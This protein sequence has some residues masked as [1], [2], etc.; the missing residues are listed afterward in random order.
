MFSLK[1][2]GSDYSFV[3]TFRSAFF[4]T[5]VLHIYFEEVDA[6]FLPE[7]KHRQL[8]EKKLI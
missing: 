6:M 8:S 1:T 5:I 7:K 3:A 2:A 4:L